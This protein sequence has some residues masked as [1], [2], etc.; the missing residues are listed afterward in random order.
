MTENT[1]TCWI[2]CDECH[3]LG[4]KN[5]KLRKK[6][7]LNYQIACEE[8]EKTNGQGTVPIRPKGHPYS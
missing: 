8:F 5:H 3:G 7:R 4:R 2:T 1:E 6:V